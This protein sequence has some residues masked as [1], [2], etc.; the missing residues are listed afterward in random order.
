MLVYSEHGLG[1]VI[2]FAR[3]VPYLVERGFEV[4]FDCHAKLVPLMGTL[5]DPGRLIPS[6]DPIPDCDCVTPIMSLPNF[7]GHGLDEI[8]DFAKATPYLSPDPGD[9]AS[10]KAEL[11]DVPGL[12]V[13]LVWQGNPT[14]STDPD[15]SIPIAHFEG[16]MALEGITAVS[17]QKIHGE[18]GIEPFKSRYRIVD[19]S[20]AK[21]GFYPLACLVSALDLVITSDTAIAHLA[22]ALGARTWLLLSAKP[23]WR[24][25]LQRDDSPWYPTMRLFRQATFRNW[26]PVFAAVE[27]AL[28]ETAADRT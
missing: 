25:L 23:S 24:W 14:Q 20:H 1:D 26:G 16:I 4:V 15:R 2:Q 11:D 3:Y 10:I 28:K 13:G 22:G 12:K 19:W 5:S 17:L 18:R 21:D 27:S 8:A 7:L 9:V 6:G